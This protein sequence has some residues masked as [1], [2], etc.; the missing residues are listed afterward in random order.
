MMQPHLQQRFDQLLAHAKDPKFEMI[1][2][3]RLAAATELVDTLLAI[4]LLMPEEWR[5]YRA[6]VESTA[7]IVGAVELKRCT[8]AART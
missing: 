1:A 5:T 6:R 7:L 3:E 4:G 8:D 2:R